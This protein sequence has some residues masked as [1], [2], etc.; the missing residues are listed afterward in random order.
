MA[1]AEEGEANRAVL[2][3]NC[4]EPGEEKKKKELLASISENRVKTPKK[5]KEPKEPKETKEAKEAKEAKTSAVAPSEPFE[6]AES[7]VVAPKTPKSKKSKAPVEDAPSTAVSGAEDS[8]DEGEKKTDG[9]AKKK[10]YRTQKVRRAEQE[11]LLQAARAQA[12]E[13]TIKELFEASAL[14]VPAGSEMEAW[15]F[16]REAA[17]MKVRLDKQLENEIVIE[18]LKLEHAKDALDRAREFEKWK[19]EQS[20]AVEE[21]KVASEAARDELLVKLVNHVIE[22]KKK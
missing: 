5:A 2:E 14:E 16:M 1:D 8:D 4:S 7:P 13:D 22:L 18:K 20:L 10:P 12:R 21:K 9:S 3:D 17:A 15:K 19:F 6:A 11:A